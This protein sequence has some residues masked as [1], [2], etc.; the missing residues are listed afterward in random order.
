VQKA[1]VLHQTEQN[2]QQRPLAPRQEQNE[3]QTRGNNATTASLQRHTCAFSLTDASLNL[4]G[5]AG[6]AT[7]F[8]TA[9]ED[10]Q[11]VHFLPIAAS[12]AF[13]AEACAV[14][15][16][17]K[18]WRSPYLQKPHVIYTDCKQLADFLKSGESSSLPCWRGARE[19]YLCRNSLDL[20]AQRGEPIKVVHV[21]RE[22]LSLVH[23]LAN[24]ARRSGRS[25]IGS[26]TLQELRYWGVFDPG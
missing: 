23:Q 15:L 12:T 5:H 14:H 18:D 8:Y 2:R 17:M 1:L 25:Y 4:N 20:A 24:L 9:S 13:Q 7:A 21:Q 19:A 10:L 16:A 11:I 6:A 22:Q 3:V 26:P